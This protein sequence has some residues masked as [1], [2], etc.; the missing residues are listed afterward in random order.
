MQVL[1]FRLCFLKQTTCCK[2]SKTYAVYS[3]SY[4]AY[5]ATKPRQGGRAAFACSESKA[6]S[7]NWAHGLRLLSPFW[8][9][10]A[11]GGLLQSSLQSQQHPGCSELQGGALLHPLG[12][13]WCKCPIS[14]MGSM[15]QLSGRKWCLQVTIVSVAFLLC[16]KWAACMLW[17][18]FTLCWVVAS[19][20]YQKVC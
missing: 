8:A 14:C 15:H 12:G 6:Q 13:L 2:C 17:C 10:S 1:T 7:T 9:L 18:I 3:V 16:W 4:L 5:N 19:A 20:C 11:L